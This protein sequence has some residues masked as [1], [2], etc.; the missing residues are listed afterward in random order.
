MINVLK[1]VVMDIFSVLDVVIVPFFQNK[2]P[3][4]T[5]CRDFCRNRPGRQ[6]LVNLP[7]KEDSAGS[8]PARGTTLKYSRTGV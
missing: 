1:K 7:S 4:T 8:N 5:L 2:D 3:I 6:W